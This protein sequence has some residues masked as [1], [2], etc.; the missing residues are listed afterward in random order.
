MGKLGPD[1]SYDL[2]SDSTFMSADIYGSNAEKLYNG[3]LGRI[4]NT[5]LVESANQKESVDAG[6]ANADIFSNFIHGSDAFGAIDLA[7]DKPQVY[8][9][10]H[11]KIDS[12]N[13]AGRFSIVSWAAS[14]VAKTLNANWLINI[15][16]GA[17]DQ[18]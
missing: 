9:I 15:K 2:T 10:P 11:T 14:Y 8:I 12:G 6:T 16:T 18:A 3:E 1:T 5:R 13:P 4:L 17:T 7:G